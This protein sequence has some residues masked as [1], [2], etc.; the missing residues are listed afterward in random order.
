MNSIYKYITKPYCH[1]RYRF[2]SIF[3][4]F[5]MR[6]LIILLLALN[7]SS[8]KKFI[9]VDA[10]ASSLNAGNVYTSDASSSA[11]LTGI[12][13]NISNLNGG[14]NGDHITAISLYAGVSADELTLFNLSD[15]QLPIYYRN[16]L[17]SQSAT[18]FWS[19]TY[20]IIFVANAA[21]E[22][23]SSSQETT[24]AVKQHLLGEAKFI[25]A[26]CYFYLVNLFGDVPLVRSTDWKINA[27]LPRTPKSEVYQQII[28]DL[29]EAQGLLSSNYLSA[30]II[31]TTTER[32][33][34]TKWAAAALLARAYLYTGDYLNAEAQ[35]SAVISNAT[36]YNLSSLSNAFLKNSTETIWSL[37]PVRTGTQSNTGEG[38]IFVLP[39]TGPNTSSYPV[40]LSNNIVNS[41]EV[42]DQRKT[43]WIKTVTVGNST[44]NYPYKYKI[45][46]VNTT[47]QEY[48]MMLRLSEQYL[49]RAEAR[50][51]QNNISG[52]QAD[53]N[54]IRAR[55]GLL[56][57]VAADKTS[58]LTAILHERR[59]EL[60]TEWGHRWFD[61]KRTNTIDAVMI[62]VAPQK[63][64]TWSPF[65]ALYPIP[66]SEIQ[67]DPKLSQNAGYL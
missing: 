36:L 18:K 19:S 25:R 67:K 58:L 33:R 12:Y 21:I 53:L 32:V 45:G 60:F 6:Y 52:A 47:T 41:F 38:G 35:A 39:A 10:P 2:N 16:D 26:F 27:Q 50:A 48:I 46:R 9:E 24:P 62:V 40:Y 28:A 5:N 66:Q 57:T 30:N 23:L 65:K 11:V 20:N 59:V 13:A 44:Y 34:P 51:Q 64:G 43:T 42:T 14:L 37:Q 1:L 7:V 55:A 8:C 54:A 4:G 17:N 61:L 15:Q 63:G 22:G 3:T 29:K 31:S 49:I 56:N